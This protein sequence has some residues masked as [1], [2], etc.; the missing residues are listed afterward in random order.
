MLGGVTVCL[1][2]ALTAHPPPPPGQATLLLLEMLDVDKALAAM[3]AGQPLDEASYVFA[4]A[5]VKRRVNAELASWWTSAAAAHSP[6]LLAW[7]AVLCLIG[8]SAGGGMRGA[9]P[10]PGRASQ[11]HAAAKQACLPWSCVCD[12]A[13]ECP[14]ACRRGPGG[15]G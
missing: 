13:S 14:A 4:G 1:R 7:A 9:R 8:K 10:R 2:A 5:E 15:R 6:V 11:A 12:C 3:A